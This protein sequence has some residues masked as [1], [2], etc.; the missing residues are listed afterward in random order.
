MMESETG[1]TSIYTIQRKEPASPRRVVP[2][3]SRRGLAGL[4]GSGARDDLGEAER[5]RAASAHSKERTLR[6]RGFADTGDENSRPAQRL[7][8]RL[9]QAGIDSH[10]EPARRL[11]VVEQH[12]Q[13]RIDPGGRLDPLP[14]IRLVGLAATSPISA[15]EAPH[16]I[17]QRY[18][19]ALEV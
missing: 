19:T 4:A 17:D 18:A 1:Q 16:P 12:E 8:R 13:L 3:E 15:H 9:R 2:A 6:R 11:W 10:Q 7:H 14:K 5:D